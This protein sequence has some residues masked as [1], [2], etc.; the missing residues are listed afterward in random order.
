MSL[1]T[2]SL[3]KTVTGVSCVI[4]GAILES[5]AAGYT[6]VTDMYQIFTSKKRLTRSLSY[7]QRTHPPPFW[8]TTENWKDIPTFNT[9]YT[10]IHSIFRKAQVEPELLIVALL[11]L[12][13]FLKRA[14]DLH[15]NSETWQRLCFVTIVLASKHWDDISCSSSSFSLCSN[16]EL[17][18]HDLNSMELIVLSTLEWDLYLTSDH[19]RDIYY[20]L[21][22]LWTNFEFDVNTGE[23]AE[24]S[25]DVMKYLSV[26]PWWGVKR[27]FGFE[28]EEYCLNTGL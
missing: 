10:F 27:V 23:A 6:D 24:V 3:N 11:Y 20:N 8:K 15:I 9:V 22:S 4:Y 17:T 14:E 7:P 16:G 28:V 18:L 12:G 5:H 19:Y 26:E 1:R 25:N 2:Q 21:K 13:E